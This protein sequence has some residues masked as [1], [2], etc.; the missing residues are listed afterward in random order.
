MRH[1]WL[2][3]WRRKE[4]LKGKEESK[5]EVNVLLEYNHA[6]F[7]TGGNILITLQQL[8]GKGEVKAS[9]EDPHQGQSVAVVAA[10]KNIS[11]AQPN[12][13]TP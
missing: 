8:P 13:N 6:T 10:G 11:S 7:S 4:S 12:A 1:W 2:L 9:V 3:H 5:K